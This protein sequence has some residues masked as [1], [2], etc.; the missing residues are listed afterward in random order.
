M[1]KLLKNWE[2]GWNWI[3]TPKPPP[4]PQFTKSIFYA[5]PKDLQHLRLS[6]ALHP[7][8]YLS[9][10]RFLPL[11][12]VHPRDSEECIFLVH[13]FWYRDVFFIW[14][15]GPCVLFLHLD[16]LYI[17]GQKRLDTEKKIEKSRYQKNRHLDTNYP[18]F[19]N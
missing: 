19:G 15:Q 8:R 10:T 7:G 14:Y 3:S 18:P 4:P 9:L 17:G 13:L 1:D 12:G 2:V 16:I 11:C 6:L 5:F